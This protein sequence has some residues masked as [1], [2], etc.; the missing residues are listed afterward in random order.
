MFQLTD[1]VK[2]LLIINVLMFIADQVLGANMLALHYPGSE[3]F[4]PYQLVTYFFMHGSI[5]HIFFNMFSLV[6]FGSLLERV[7]GPRR[8]LFYYLFC[9][10]GAAVLHIVVSYY[11]FNQLESIMQAF[12]QNPNYT[13]YSHFFDKVPLEN[14]NIE[15]K[16]AVLEMGELVDKG[17]PDVIPEATK[18]MEMFINYEKNVPMVGASGAIFGLLLAF[19]VLFPENELYLLFLPV[20][21]KAKIF[22]PL[23]MVVELYMG[24]RQ[25]AWDNV[26]HFAHL[27]GALFGFLLILYW[28][29]RGDRLI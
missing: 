17:Q 13:T 7:W 6:M 8:F 16:E 22:V 12:V 20:P 21:I 4:Q 15:F 24:N 9:A 10:I 1:V 23:L 25:F 5:G 3:H 2:N 27:G 19:G 11:Q 28:Q 18:A 29:K 14:L 26:A